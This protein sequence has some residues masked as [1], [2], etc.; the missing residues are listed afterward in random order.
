[1]KAFIKGSLL[2][3]ALT[4]M[5]VGG[6]AYGTNQSNQSTV[7]QGKVAAPSEVAGRCDVRVGYGRVTGGNDCFY[8]EVM[9]GTR[10]GLILCADVTVTCNN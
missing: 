5:A 1:M 9:V 4:A 10:S 3:A 2:G 6:Y 7:R 8:N